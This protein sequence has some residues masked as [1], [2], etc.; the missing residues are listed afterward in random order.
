MIFFKKVFVGLIS[1]LVFSPLAFASEDFE[2]ES[3]NQEVQFF[4]KTYERDGV[5]KFVSALNVYIKGE[6]VAR[7]RNEEFEAGSTPSKFVFENSDLEIHFDWF[8]ESLFISRKGK[9]EYT[10]IGR[11]LCH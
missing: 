4:G 7:I 9:K 5:E 11:L 8:A 6:R 10:Y 2:C 1:I 3:Q